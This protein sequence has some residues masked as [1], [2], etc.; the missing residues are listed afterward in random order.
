MAG[1]S[2]FHHLPGSLGVTAIIQELQPH[3]F[4]V[5]KCTTADADTDL[6]SYKETVCS[7]CFCDCQHLD[8][9]T[10]WEPKPQFCSPRPQKREAV[11]SL[12]C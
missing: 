1:D 8:L 12:Q 4:V 3:H 9:A 5:A 2:W 10:C 11:F 6:Q 7:D